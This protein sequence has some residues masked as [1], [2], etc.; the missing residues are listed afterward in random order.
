MQLEARH[1]RRVVHVGPTMAPGGMASV[2]HL[3]AANPPDGWR[4]SSCNTFSTQGIR[5]KFKRWRIAKNEGEAKKA[6]ARQ[7]LPGQDRGGGAAGGA[8]GAGGHFPP[9]HSKI[10]RGS[11]NFPVGAATALTPPTSDKY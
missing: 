2:I 9:E 4:A 10:G 8:A 5:R 6:K 7:N 3:L 11:E 1:M